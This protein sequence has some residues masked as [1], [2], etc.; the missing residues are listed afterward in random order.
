MNK[1]KATQDYFYVVGIIGMAIGS[2]GKAGFV[3]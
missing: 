3:V 1:A 2:A